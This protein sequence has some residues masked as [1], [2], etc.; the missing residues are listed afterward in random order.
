MALYVNHGD[1]HADLN[2]G[3]S[4]PAQIQKFKLLFGVPSRTQKVEKYKQN[5]GG[6]FDGT[7]DERPLSSWGVTAMQPCINVGFSRTEGTFSACL[8]EKDHNR[9]GENVP[10]KTIN[11]CSNVHEAFFHVLAKRYQ[12]L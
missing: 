11:W 4:P 2:G 6:R 1:L 3:V 10:P 7:T 12:R 9:F 8:D 5:H